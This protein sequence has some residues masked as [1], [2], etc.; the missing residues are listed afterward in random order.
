MY[1]KNLS[2]QSQVANAF[3]SQSLPI[4]WS[5]LLSPFGRFR[6]RIAAQGFLHQLC[7]LQVFLLFISV[8]DL[9]RFRFALSESSGLLVRIA[10]LYHH[11]TIP[12]PS[13]LEIGINPAPKQAGLLKCVDLL[14]L[15]SLFY[16]L[17]VSI[18][19]V[20]YDPDLFPL[21]SYRYGLEIQNGE[22]LSLS[23]CCLSKT[24][25]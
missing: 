5:S 20:L 1:Q 4:F 22:R 21:K 6:F 11:L 16:V 23:V 13:P 24:C 10:H 12:P 25:L 8:R 3:I 17:L 9:A 15:S 7:S 18:L 19:P 2:R 14:S